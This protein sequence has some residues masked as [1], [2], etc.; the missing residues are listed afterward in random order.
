MAAVRRHYR[1]GEVQP[2]AKP[3]PATVTGSRTRP[4]TCRCRWRIA[5]LIAFRQAERLPARQTAPSRHT[6]E[7]GS[8]GP[9][10][11]TTVSAGDSFH[12]PRESR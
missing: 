3:R 10:T 6:V 11:Q 8:Q 12:R 2:S 7:D 1:R 5:R 9:Q 4:Q